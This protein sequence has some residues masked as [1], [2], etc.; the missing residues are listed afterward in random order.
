MHFSLIL[1]TSSNRWKPYTTQINIRSST[2]HYAFGHENIYLSHENV[3]YFHFGLNVI[4]EYVCIIPEA[5]FIFSRQGLSQAI[6][7]WLTSHV[8]RYLDALRRVKRESNVEFLTWR[9]FFRFLSFRPLFSIASL[10][11]LSYCFFF[12]FSH[13]HGVQKVE[14]NRDTEAKSLFFSELQ[15]WR[16]TEYKCV[17][18]LHVYSKC[19][20]T[21]ERS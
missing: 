1:L 20:G 6:A 2:T 13:K 9:F 14:T 19:A 16:E 10:R 7:A 15:M 4:L 8:V 17:I 12:P 21:W 5:A 18:T 3:L 11:F